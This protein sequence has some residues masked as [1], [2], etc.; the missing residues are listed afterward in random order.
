MAV[1]LGFC[2]DRRA[3]HPSGGRYRAV[4]AVS[5]VPV[6]VRSVAGDDVRLLLRTVATAAL[7][8]WSIWC[9]TGE[10]PQASYLARLC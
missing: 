9:E 6:I 7:L 2:P 4:A 3:R 10:D 1:V 5:P 8:V